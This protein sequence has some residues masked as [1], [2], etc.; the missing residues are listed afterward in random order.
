MNIGN[1]H[2]TPT[3]EGDVHRFYEMLQDYPDFYDDSI[4][5][6]SLYEFCKLFDDIVKDSL[7]LKKGDEVVGWIY[8]DTLDEKFATYNILFKRRSVDPS[9][10]PSVATEALRY[11]FNK[12]D[13]KMIGGI[14]RV[15][16]FA[17]L[18]GLKQVGAVITG[19]MPKHEN[20]NGEPI[21]C[22][23]AGILREVLV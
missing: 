20:I 1:I 21:D 10:T 2:L 15:N 8:L 6:N 19:Y 14:V 23:Y 9:Y 17:A 13:V 22:V 18:R 3:K 12:H 7:T 5:L 4:Q 11:F 16:N